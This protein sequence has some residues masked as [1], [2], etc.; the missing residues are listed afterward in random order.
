MRSLFS[1]IVSAFTNSV[2][3]LA[4]LHWLRK[5]TETLTEKVDRILE[6]LSPQPAVTIEFYVDGERVT[7]KDMTTTQQVA[8]SIAPL[9]KHGAPAVVDGAPV[10]TTDNSDVLT[11]EAATDGLSA[12]VKAAGPIGTATVTVTVDADLGAGVRPLIG[13]LDVEVTAGEATS[14]SITAGQPTEQPS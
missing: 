2:R 7:K 4:E 1:L 8:V 11:I 3:I 13:T 10:W 9:D 14:I 5:Q 12:T 6:L